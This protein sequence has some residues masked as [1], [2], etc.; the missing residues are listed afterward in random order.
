MFKNFFQ[1]RDELDRAILAGD[2]ELSAIA[3]AVFRFLLSHTFYTAR[4]Y[5]HVNYDVC[6]T[7]TLMSLTGYAERSVKRA[8]HDLKAARLIHV[9]PRPKYAGGSDPAEVSIIWAVFHAEDEDSESATEAPSDGAESATEAPESATEAPS[10][11]REE[12]KE[13][14]T[15]SRRD[16]DVAGSSS[17]PSGDTRDRASTR[18]KGSARPK[19][20]AGPKAS[21]RSKAS[22]AGSG[23]RADKVPADSGVPD[24]YPDLGEYVADLEECLGDLASFLSVDEGTIEVKV[25]ARMFRALCVRYGFTCMMSDVLDAFPTGRWVRVSRKDNPVGYLL[26]EIEREFI[27]QNDEA[28]A[29]DPELEERF[30]KLFDGVEC[31][32][33]Y[34]IGPRMPDVDSEIIMALTKRLLEEGRIVKDYSRPNSYKL[35]DKVPA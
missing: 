7:E 31:V 8:I 33:G 14:T 17:T 26:N 5:G 3:L 23:A 18:T 11:L 27:K 32:A 30:L 2:I 25:L 24:D 16:D 22:S 13:P 28:D 35:A 12:R 29:N 10:F 1:A 4:S 15:S 9:R 20:S 21:A 19:G 34:N 6:G